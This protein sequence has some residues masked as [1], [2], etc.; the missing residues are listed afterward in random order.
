MDGPSPCPRSPETPGLGVSQLR[1]YLSRHGEVR[2]G[3]HA[4]RLTPL[5][6]AVFFICYTLFMFYRSLRVGI[7]GKPILLLKFRTFKKGMDGGSPTASYN[8]PRMTR[9][10]RFL[11]RTKLDELPTLW[12]VL[13][14]DLSLVGPR[15]DVP[16]ELESLHRGVRSLVLSVKPGIISPATIWNSNEDKLLKDEKDPHKAY[17]EK[18]KPKKYRLNC[19]YVTQKSFLFDLRV[20]L[21]FIFRPKKDIFKIFPNES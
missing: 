21:T 4:S 16:E 1:T 13:R 5:L 20:I 9:L 19:W 11:R 3:P 18:I 2:N 10:G 17:L 12:N 6:G 7:N 14:G 15:P 8:D